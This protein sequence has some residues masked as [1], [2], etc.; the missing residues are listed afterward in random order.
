MPLTSPLCTIADVY[1]CVEKFPRHPRY[2][3]G[4]KRGAATY[5]GRRPERRA[6]S[7][8]FKRFSMIIGAP[9]SPSSRYQVRRDHQI[10]CSWLIRT[11]E[12][13]VVGKYRWSLEL[14]FSAHTTVCLFATTHPGQ[15]ITI[16]AGRIS[17]LV[18]PRPRKLA[19]GILSI[20]ERIDGKGCWDSY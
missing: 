13:I 12:V 4:L 5:F 3:W 2:V 19:K 1:A 17:T 16:C 18:A 7:S 14:R 10:V 15:P 6:K 9:T 8:T 20:D 11:A